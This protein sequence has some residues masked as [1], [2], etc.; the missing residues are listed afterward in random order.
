MSALIGLCYPDGFFSQPTPTL[1]TWR[2][3]GRKGCDAVQI[4][5]NDLSPGL[6]FLPNRW[7]LWAP[8]LQAFEWRL[9]GSGAD[10][11]TWSFSP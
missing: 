1:R 8:A 7:S 11:K 9:E 6:L 3:G 5:R 2:P 10:S 4:A